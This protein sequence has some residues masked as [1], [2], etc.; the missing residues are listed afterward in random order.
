[1]L[2]INNLGNDGYLSK[3]QQA[4]FNVYKQRE[5]NH[6]ILEFHEKKKKNS[7]ITD[8]HKIRLVLDAKKNLLLF[9]QIW[10][11]YFIEFSIA[12]SELKEAADYR[13]F[14]LNQELRLREK[15]AFSY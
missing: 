6:E 3:D 9:S 11:K 7:R 1:M 15:K 2:L 4:S 8:K 5:E 14:P 13:H 12:R 10:A